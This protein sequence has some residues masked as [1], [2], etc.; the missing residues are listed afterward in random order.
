[1][2]EP[3]IFTILYF[4]VRY[5]DNN[6][7]YFRAYTYTT[8]IILVISVNYNILYCFPFDIK[9]VTKYYNEYYFKIITYYYY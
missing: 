5:I 3:I 4:I 6:I 8:Y 1:M 9:I 2:D 7:L